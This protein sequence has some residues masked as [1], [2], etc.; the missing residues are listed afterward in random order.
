MAT[1][2][3]PA[4]KVAAKA[5]GVY[6]DLVLTFPLRP[7]RTEAE[8]DEAIEIVAD[9]AARAER[10][11]LEPGERDYLDVLVKL[12]EHYEAEHYPAPG[13]SG[14]AMVRFL[15]DQHGLNQAETAN[16]AGISVTTFSELLSGRRKMSTKHVRALAQLFGVPADVV[17]G[18]VE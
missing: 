10:H 18:D 14:P 6:L 17:I 12:V 11:D 9:L 8:N 2:A 3:A 1:K 7:I 4:R 13:V 16:R 15:M 5:S